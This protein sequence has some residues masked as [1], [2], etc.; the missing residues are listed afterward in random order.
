M[1]FSGLKI[2]SANQ[3]RTS[4]TKFLQNNILSWM[5]SRS[6]LIAPWMEEITI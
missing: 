5:E 2:C 3:K 4:P 1:H 6:F